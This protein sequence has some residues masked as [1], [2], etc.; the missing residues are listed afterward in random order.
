MN[1]ETQ[2]TEFNQSWHDEHVKLI[3]GFADLQDGNIV[4]GVDNA[5]TAVGVVCRGIRR[6]EDEDSCLS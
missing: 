2:S 4:L 6:R 5:V 1:R 3:C